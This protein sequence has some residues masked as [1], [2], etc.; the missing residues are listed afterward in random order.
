[1]RKV[2]LPL[3]AFGFLAACEAGRS[4]K[5]ERVTQRINVNPGEIE[6]QLTWDETVHDARQW[7][8]RAQNSFSQQNISNAMILLGRSIMS[9][10]AAI[11]RITCVDQHE[12]IFRM[13]VLLE[14]RSRV[15]YLYYSSAGFELIDLVALD[16]RSALHGY[17]F[18]SDMGQLENRS[19]AMVGATHAQSR[20][21]SVGIEQYD[22]LSRSLAPL[23]RALEANPGAADR[24]EHVALQ[25]CVENARHPE[26]AAERREAARRAQLER[27]RLIEAERQQA[28]R[29][30][31]AREAAER[32]E[33]GEREE[34]ERAR[35]HFRVF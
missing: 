5:H 32:R 14:E 25:Q 17:R 20:V 10:S 26:A 31:A 24:R 7:L 33:R 21:E 15:R 28:E 9:Y 29:Q 3:L 16:A 23:M 27:Q 4:A 22:E 35:R 8:A 2:L 6:A 11:E 18:L 19:R 30:R 1:V 12:D 13:S 34:R